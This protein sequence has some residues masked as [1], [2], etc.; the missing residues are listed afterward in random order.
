MAQEHRSLS[1]PVV[2]A[3]RVIAESH[4]SVRLGQPLHRFRL[5]GPRATNQRLKYESLLDRLRHVRQALEYLH[6]VI[7][8]LDIE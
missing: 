5:S 8:K 6:V 3:G 4:M 2:A 1:E 7:R